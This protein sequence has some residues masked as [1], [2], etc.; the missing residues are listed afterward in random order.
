MLSSSPSLS[1]AETKKPNKG[2]RG[3]PEE[4]NG[5]TKKIH[6]DDSELIERRSN[7]SELLICFLPSLFQKQIGSL[8]NPF[9]GEMA[10]TEDDYGVG[11]HR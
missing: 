4:V 10:L 5:R 9:S 3:K 8:T 1:S 11:K 2:N 7:V 6:E